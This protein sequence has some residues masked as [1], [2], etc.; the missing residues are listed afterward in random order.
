MRTPRS[1]A[2][3]RVSLMLLLF[4]ACDEANPRAVSEGDLAPRNVAQTSVAAAATGAQGQRDTIV[5]LETPRRTV[6]CKN[7]AGGQ[8]PPMLEPRS[9]V[10][11]RGAGVGLRSFVGDTVVVYGE[12]PTRGAILD[13]GPL[14]MR[15]DSL[16]VISAG[17]RLRVGASGAP[18]P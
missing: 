2:I 14:S 12:A 11:L 1:G 3:R 15:L 16:R 5:V 17:Q 18:L 8:P 9:I 4:A 7:R 10:M 6:D 13:A